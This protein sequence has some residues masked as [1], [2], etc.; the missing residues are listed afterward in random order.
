MQSRRRWYAG[1]V[2]GVGLGIVGWSRRG[3]QQLR[4]DVSRTK[5]ERG[6][7]AIYALIG[8]LSS[9]IAANE[10]A[11]MNAAKLGV[12]LSYNV[13]LRRTV[14]VLL[15]KTKTGVRNGE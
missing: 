7:D 1:P 9:I 6:D 14:R 2:D 11:K 5:K 13:S 12:R 8:V 4:Q 10:T 15:I 3:E